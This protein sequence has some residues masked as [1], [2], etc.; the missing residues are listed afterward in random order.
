MVMANGRI[1]QTGPASEMESVLQSAYLGST[2][3]AEAG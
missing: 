1:L 2:K 3:S